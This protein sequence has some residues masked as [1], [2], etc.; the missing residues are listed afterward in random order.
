LI[1]LSR[2][3]TV[4]QSVDDVAHSYGCGVRSASDVVLLGNADVMY[5]VGSVVIIYNSKQHN[6]RHYLGHTA[7]VT[8]Y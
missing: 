5:T 7:A 1:D 2:T 6:Q 3:K 8:W 4:L